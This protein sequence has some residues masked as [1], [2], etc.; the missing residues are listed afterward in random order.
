MKYQTASSTPTCIM[1]APKRTAIRE[2][3]IRTGLALKYV[4]A[5]FHRSVLSQ[6]WANIK[7]R[8]CEA[9]NYAS[10]T[11]CRGCGSYPSGIHWQQSL[12]GAADAADVPSQLLVVYPLPTF[13][14]EDML[15]RE[16]KRLE[17]EKPAPAKTGSDAPKLK[18]TAPTSTGQG[19]GASQG[20]L[21]RVFLMR[22]AQSNESFKYGFAEFWTLEDAAAAMKK[23]TMARNFSIAGCAV[24]ISTIHM[25]VFLP[26]DRELTPVTEAQ[27]FHPLFNPSIRVRY[28]DGHVYPSQLMVAAEP[29]GGIREQSTAE[30]QEEA[31]RAKKRKADGPLGNSAK[32]PLAMAGKMAVW[33]R[34]HDELHRG[35]AT[36]G[37]GSSEAGDGAKAQPSKLSSANSTI[38]ISL[39]SA[40]K[41]TGPPETVSSGA[42]DGTSSAAASDKDDASAPV[43]YVDRD[44]LMCLIC[45]RKYKSVDEVNIHERSRNHKTATEDAELVK[46]ALPRL[47]VRDKRLQKQSGNIAAEP[48]S[49]DNASTAAES[50]YRD[51]AKERR[52]VYGH[53]K[54]AAQQQDSS[55]EKST[56]HNTVSATASKSGPAASK[57][58]S[59]LAKMGWTAGAGLGANGEGRT[60]VLE[61]NAYQEGVGLGAEGGNLGDA[62]ERAGRQTRGGYAEYVSSVQ[63]KARERYNKLG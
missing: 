14:D 36:P 57:G 4:D 22:D 37:E 2:V 3:L 30:E 42:A 5:Y 48:S 21:H 47:V 59:L 39:S 58:A 60:E 20:S 54:K 6:A 17:L 34:K 7:H 12:T 33:Q 11:T 51:R 49:T 27:S 41:L 35:D 18:S 26:E 29:P 53:Q 23:F 45:M 52:H 46:A 38:K 25:G 61:T 56:T 13:L 28:R 32:K 44:R 50:Q 9:S 55:K 63:D 16:M 62:A 19:F 24:T 43:S 8:Q 10:R 40:S 31:K 1:R 15:A